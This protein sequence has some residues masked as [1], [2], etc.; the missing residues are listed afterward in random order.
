[1]YRGK[2]AEKKSYM[3]FVYLSVFWAIS[4]QTV[5][6]FLY[7]GLGGRPFWN[8]A[9]LAPR[10]FVGAWTYGPAFL[11]IALSAIN[12]FS[13]NFKV[14]EEVFNILKKILSFTMPLNLFLLFCEVFKEFYTDNAHTIASQ[15]LFFGLDGHHKL[16]PYIWSA[17]AFNIFSAIVYTTNLREKKKLLLFTCVL[18]ILGTWIE[19][20]IGLVI[21]AFVPSSLGEIVEYSPSLGEFWICLGIWSCGILAFTVN[22][23]ICLAIMSGELREKKV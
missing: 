11:I 13:G 18:T 6:A 15:Y 4:I 12:K 20:G 17:I 8:S 19:K 23:K 21:P 7:F 3:P 10:F 16:V 2:T 9:I 14:K 1:M 22:S 5:S